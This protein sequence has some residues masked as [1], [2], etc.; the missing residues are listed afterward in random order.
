MMYIW[1]GTYMHQKK[2]N[3]ET[4]TMACSIYPMIA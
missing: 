3:A 2:A 1:K 4:K